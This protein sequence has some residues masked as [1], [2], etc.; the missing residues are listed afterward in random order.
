MFVDGW[1][2][3]EPGDWQELWAHK[4]PGSFR[5]EQSDWEQPERHTWVAQLDKAIADCSRPPVLIAHSLGCL[6][7]AHWVA[8]GAGR[9]V[10]A[11][12]LVTPADVEDNPEPAIQGFDPIPRQAFPFPT[13]VAASSSDR[14][15]TP[16][17]AR[18]FADR[19]G[20]QFADA[21][22]VGHLTVKGGYGPWPLGERLLDEFL[23][24]AG[25]TDPATSFTTARP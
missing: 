2:G 11:A 19:W 8:E 17:R 15:M 12:M 18:Y 25:L 16:E 13:L 22:D 9:P 14:W 1:F 4:L 3:P 7:V 24:T 10:R 5:L 6:T 21:G 20:A 23:A